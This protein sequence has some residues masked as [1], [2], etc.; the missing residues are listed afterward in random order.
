MD[1]NTLLILKTYY[2]LELRVCFRPFSFFRFANFLGS[3]KY[4][5]FG[6]TKVSHGIAN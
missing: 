1:K 2:V 4:L 5:P 3:I 6:H